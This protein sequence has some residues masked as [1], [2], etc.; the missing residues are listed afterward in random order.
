V[1]VTAHRDGL[2]AKNVLLGSKMTIDDSE[3]DDCEPRETTTVRL[4]TL[5]D[6]P[7]ETDL[8]IVIEG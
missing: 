7:L 1:L 6:E 4:T 2:A 5:R 8:V 3:D